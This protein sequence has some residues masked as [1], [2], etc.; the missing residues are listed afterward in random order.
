MPLAAYRRALG[1][2]GL[3]LN[4]GPWAEA[5]MAAETE[6]RRQVNWGELGI[7]PIHPEHG[8]ALL[9][10]LLQEQ[11]AQVGVV[12]V[13]WR[14][15]RTAFFGDAAPPF[16]AEWQGGAEPMAALEMPAQQPSPPSQ[17]MKQ[18]MA[19]RPAERR[20]RLNAYIRARVAQ[21]LRSSPEAISSRQ[22]LFQ[23]GLDSLMAI[24]LKT[25][26]ASE[27]A[28]ALPQTFLFDYPTVEAMVDFLLDKLACEET[29]GLEPRSAVEDTPPVPHAVDL[30]TLLAAASQM[31]E[32]D[33]A[34]ELAGNNVRPRRGDATR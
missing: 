18:L 15:F 16:F 20:T 30:E 26:F 5:G 6:K 33:I 9:G 13:N 7:E 4:W 1:L 14:R 10:R 31:T 12:R 23:A 34:R 27:L 24:E 17:L 32:H 8:V 29:P 2:V 3:S 25:M 11:T 28:L 21:V 22:G 19:E